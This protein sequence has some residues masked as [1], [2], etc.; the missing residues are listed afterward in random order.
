[1]KLKRDLWNFLLRIKQNPVTLIRVLTQVSSNISN[2]RFVASIERLAARGVL[3]IGN[4]LHKHRSGR[5][6]AENAVD[7]DDVRCS[8]SCN[9]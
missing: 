7:S 4:S 2:L 9:N 6:V 3:V 8:G 1:M 5:E